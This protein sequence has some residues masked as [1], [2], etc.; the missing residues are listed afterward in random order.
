M[1]T[2]VNGLRVHTRVDG[3]KGGRPLVLL[4]GY[5]TCGSLWR[6]CVPY[7]A[8][9]F[10]VYVPDLP[11]HGTPHRRTTRDRVLLVI[12]A[13]TLAAFLVAYVI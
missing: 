4:H 2:R 11:G 1:E 10:R 3:P 7:L 9:R 12:A 13:L 5:P 6:N 8:E